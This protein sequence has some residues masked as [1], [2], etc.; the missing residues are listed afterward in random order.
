[1]NLTQEQVDQYRRDGLVVVKSL[2]S[3][4]EVRRMSEAFDRDSEVEGPQRVLE[5]DGQRVRAVYASHERQPEFAAFVRSPRVLGAAQQLLCEDLYVY[6]FKINAKPALGG[7][8]WAWHQDFLAWQIVDRLPAPRQVNVGLFLDAVTE[9][10]GPVIFVPGSHGEGLVHAGRQGTKSAQ[11]LDPEDIALPREQLAE[12]VNANGMVS[13][14]GPAGTVVFFSPEIVHGSA[15]NMSPFARRLLIATYN[16]VTNL[17]SWPGEPRPAYVVG[18][19]T[20]PL[21]QIGLADEAL[22]LGPM[23]EAATA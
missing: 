21:R 5:E 14:T 12:L 17:P 4:E 10:N 16:D 18:R 7:E 3:P 6:Q 9:F 2:F 20:T 8:R 23:V 11:H 1:V 13:P 19:D 22:A 15:P